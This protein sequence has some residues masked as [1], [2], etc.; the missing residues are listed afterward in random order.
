MTKH[1]RGGSTPVVQSPPRHKGAIQSH[2][3]PPHRP[4]SYHDD[5]EKRSLRSQLEASK[6]QTEI[7]KGLASSSSAY[8]A[9]PPMIASVPMSTLSERPA[10]LIDQRIVAALTELDVSPTATERPGP[11]TP[12]TPTGL[13]RNLPE[14]PTKEMRD[15]ARIFLG[16]SIVVGP[17]ASWQSLRHRFSSI[18][19]N[20][21]LR[22]LSSVQAPPGMTQRQEMVTCILEWISSHAK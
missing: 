3:T 5:S 4:E 15:M 17:T 10:S 13:P 21:M 9:P 6:L 7:W 12:E 22:L 11:T 18:P 14:R 19:D 2:S 8:R 16:P 20:H 1:A